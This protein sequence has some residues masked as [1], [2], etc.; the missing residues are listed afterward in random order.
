MTTY[1]NNFKVKNGLDVAGNINASILKLKPQ[2]RDN[3]P[4]G[5]S[6]EII[7]I[8]DS[9]NDA[10]ASSSTSNMVAYWDGITEHWTYI[11]N[12]QPVT[13]I[14]AF[15]LLINTNI[16]G[17]SANNQFIFPGQGTYTIDWGDGIIESTSGSITHTYANP[18]IYTIRVWDTLENVEFDNTNDCYKVL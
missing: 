10:A 5:T 3:L 7:V 12:N 14:R 2:F 11:N 16:I 9:N 4:S 18:N 15:T 1:N 8:S 6:G 13:Y 17:D